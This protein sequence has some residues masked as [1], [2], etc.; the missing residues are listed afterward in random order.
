[1]PFETIQL[2]LAAD[3]ATGGTFTAGY[4]SGTT[5][6][7]FDGGH[8]HLMVANQA[9]FKAPEDFT[10]SFDDTQ[11]TVTYNG[12]TTIKANTSVRLQLDR[13]GGSALTVYDAK[14][15]Q[16]I[17]LPKNITKLETVY[18]DF[19][20]PAAASSNGISLS[21]SVVVATTPLAALNGAL[22]SGGSVTFDVARNVV[23]AWTG[24]SVLTV[25]GFDDNGIALQEKSGSG[26]SF[27]GKKAFKK[28][29][30]CS[31]SA[32]VTGAT[33]GS[34][35]LLGIPLFVENARSILQEIYNDVAIG[36]VKPAPTRI[37]WFG[38]SVSVLAGT[39]ANLEIV[40]P[41]KGF[42]KELGVV[43]R[44]AVTT[45]GNVT[46]KVGTTDVL[47]LTVAVANGSV[48][49]TK[50]TDTP[51]ASDTTH[52]FNKGDRIQIVFDDAF[53]TAG[54]LDGYLDLQPTDVS[55]GALV[56]G[57]S[58]ATKSTATTGDV[59]GTYTPATAPDAT[60]QIGLLLAVD[61]IFLGNQQ[62]SG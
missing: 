25:Q 40:A 12:A 57:L 61:K 34:G 38:D 28:I 44:V 6:G 13:P 35:V 29:T 23:A 36:G 19:G 5:D 49:G 15:K 31:F 33:I 9:V 32:D 45:G 4:P 60:A 42:I 55:S 53:A 50:T 62:F 41:F 58:V 2:T 39:V 20:S 59:R 18:V 37:D 26:T 16:T 8:E 48:K 43:T 30:S 7:N 47:G 56:P 14:T 3:V 27:T 24:T 10:I 11:V 52:T 17:S 21:Q 46:V 51:T 1:M 54:A 22:A